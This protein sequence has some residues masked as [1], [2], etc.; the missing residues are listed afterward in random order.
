MQSQLG[1]TRLTQR[2]DRCERVLFPTSFVGHKQTGV[3][4]LLA[5]KEEKEKY[6]TPINIVYQKLH[7]HDT[8]ENKVSKGKFAREKDTNEFSKSGNKDSKS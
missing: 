3:A 6:H 2:K 5:H 8:L 4:E 7:G 1:D